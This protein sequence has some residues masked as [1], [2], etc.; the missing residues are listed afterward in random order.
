M[1]TKIDTVYFGPSVMGRGEEVEEAEQK[2][3]GNCCI[4]PNVAYTEHFL[5]NHFGVYAGKY[6][7]DVSSGLYITRGHLWRKLLLWKFMQTT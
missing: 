7:P 4:H 6:F 2:F 1:N 5:V 3:T